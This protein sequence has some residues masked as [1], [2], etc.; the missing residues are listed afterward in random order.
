MWWR[1]FQIVDSH[2]HLGDLGPEFNV[3]L[4]SA[5]LKKIMKKY[6]YKKCILACHDNL[7]TREAVEKFPDL[8]GLV[9]I[10]PREKKSLNKVKFYLKQ[11]RFIGV[12]L[13]PLFHAYLPDSEIVYPIA[14]AAIDFDRPIQFHSGHPPFSLPWS[15]EPLARR[16]PNLK[17]VLVHMGHGHIV[18]INAAIE[19]A[20]RNHNVHLETS[21]M[22]MHT[23][24]KEA[25]E[26]VGRE[27]VMY[28]SDLPCGHPAWE[29]EKIRVSGLKREDLKK[30]LQTN[31]EKLYK[32]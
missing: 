30:I 8:F 5:G 22:P 16:F 25:V 17:M 4:D 19:I 3:K 9:W 1:K 7:L 18:Y 28:G 12:K 27:K 11:D 32:I 15:Y 29:L 24:V 31:A 10:D 23:K 2:A 13:H 26:I 21:A 14:K 20:R 6:N